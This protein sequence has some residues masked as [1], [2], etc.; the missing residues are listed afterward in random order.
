MKNSKKGKIILYKAKD[1]HLSVDVKLQNETVWL[2]QKQMAELFNVKIPAINK[3]LKNVFSSNELNQKSVISILETT[4]KDRKKYKTNFYNLD[5][6]ISV[7]YRVNSSQATQFRIWATNTLKNHILKGFTINQK[8]LQ[9][10]GLK[11]LEQTLA[12]IKNTISTKQ[13]TT[14][15]T[16]GLLE[17]ITEHTES[18]LLLQKYDKNKL[19]PPQNKKKTTYK[20]TFNDALF[21]ISNLKE[22][23]EANQL[24]GR[25]KDES[26]QG[27]IGNIYQTFNKKELYKSLEEKAAHLLY[28]VIKDHPFTDGNKRIGILLFL[29][30]LTK[31]NALPKQE[32]SNTALVAL[33]LLIAES[34]PKQ[35]E[36]IILLIMNFI[37]K[38]P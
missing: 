9:E 34:N 17:I 6:I 26:F 15:E 1:G 18:W 3:H 11:E 37:T 13:L 24:F 38:T 22:N 35:K 36:T 12:L 32:F 29:I 20:L 33:A 31:N 10:R 30:F 27:I 21:A 4:A 25:Q 7:G 19:K 2:T 8:R 5:A 14:D 28:F 16:T 23:Q